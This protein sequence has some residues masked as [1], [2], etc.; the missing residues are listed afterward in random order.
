[1]SLAGTRAARAAVVLSCAVA[2]MLPQATPLRAQAA[3][4]PEQVLGYAL[5]ERF[6][7]HGGVVR[8]FERLA[9]AAPTMVRLQPYGETPEGR[10]LVQAVIARPDHL[11]RLDE[12]LRM[13]A[14]LSD[15][16][17]SPQQMRDVAASNPAVVYFSYGVHGNESSSSEAA[18]WTAWDLVR[19]APDVAGV[20]DSVVVIIDPVA[21]PDG[22]DRYVNWYRQA[23]GAR[24]NASPEAREH[25]EPWPGG[26]VNHYH[27]DLNRDWSWATQPE[28]QARL[29][30]WHRWNPQVHVD[31]HEMGY[32]SSYFFFP[33]AAPINPLYPKHILDWGKYFGDANAAAFDAHGL[34]YYTGEGFDLFYP[35]YGDS[36]PSLL[37]AIGMTYEQAGHSRAGQMIERPDGDT[38]TLA[39]RA[40]N[41]RMTG[42]ATLRASAARRSDLLADFGRF[43][44][45]MGENLPDIVI[46]P[47]DR[48]REAALLELLGR[49][50]IQVQRAARAFRAETT[51]HAGFQA[52]REFPTG[53][54]LVRARQPRGRL[55]VTLLLP[56]I[57]LDAAY[58]YD[59]SA[60]S[61][62]F[63]YGIEAHSIE[64]TPDAGWS[65]AVAP[66]RSAAAMPASA[67]YGFLAE[68]G[69]EQWPTVIRYL[70]AGGRARVLNKPFTIAGKQWPAGT[71]FFPRLGVQGYLDKVRDSGLLEI[72][73]P[74]ASGRATEGNDL[75]TGE[76]LTLELPRVAL[77]SGEGVS[78][79]AMGAQWF[80]LEQTMR[81]PFDQ[82]P[83]N[84]VAGADLSVY[85]VI[86]APDMGRTALG[87]A[88]NTALTQWIRNGGTLVATGSAAR[89]VGAAVAEVKLREAPKEPDSSR[90]ARAL[91][92]REER[93]LDQWREQVPGAILT[94]QLDTAHQLAFGSCVSGDPSRLYEL[95]SGAQV[96]EPDDAFESVGHFRGELEKVSGV[97]SEK[98]LD[99][100]E[101]GSWL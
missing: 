59:I 7:D 23:R 88:G 16:A 45:T 74:V 96:F 64:R 84:R 51:P 12:I 4:S 71:L 14:L 86:I 33:A 48:G 32:T 97:I 47:G 58:S 89:G 75:G 101:R 8:Y 35:G 31:F 24:P 54:L 27:F 10:S 46:V 95:L 78:A 82:L 77:L 49:Q 1:M 80:F 68:P 17:T 25:W 34:A 56:E 38:L 92:G 18:M 42:N 9:A 94:V 41:H 2:T 21:N 43:H 70:E 11:Q 40:S 61:L 19:G 91:R 98:N 67:P 5:G 50:G 69:F 87:E 26:R 15:P 76:S 39:G 99:K 53:T 100:L 62:P 72:A 29:A 52:R 22:R 36:W 60:W 37:G 6:T 79:N 83:I 65:T 55:A 30:T 44:A 73:V 13:N 81:I 20:L 93:E 90:I 28:T 66:L 85:D 57:V 3:P 63:A